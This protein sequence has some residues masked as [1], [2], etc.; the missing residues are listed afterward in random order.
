MTKRSELPLGWGWILQSESECEEAAEAVEK[1]IHYQTRNTDLPP[2]R[3]QVCPHLLLANSSADVRNYKTQKGEIQ[4]RW[5]VFYVKN[6]K[7]KAT[8]SNLTHASLL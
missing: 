2:R 8:S 3:Q 4:K 5:T 1:L 6:Y 7:K